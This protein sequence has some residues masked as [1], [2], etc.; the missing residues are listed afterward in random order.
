M[1]ATYRI[2]ITEQLRGNP[3]IDYYD[4]KM[5]LIEILNKF[6][7][8]TL[9]EMAKNNKNRFFY[10]NSQ[11]DIEERMLEKMPNNVKRQL[12]TQAN[13]LAR[14]GQKSENAFVAENFSTTYTRGGHK[15]VDGRR[16]Y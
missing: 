7:E 2:S 1:D 4:V 15:Y 9:R 14:G 10:R 13:K 8:D 6:D 11:S 3:L 5:D 12:Q 16:I